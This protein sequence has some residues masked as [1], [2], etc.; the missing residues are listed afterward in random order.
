MLV[1][2]FVESKSLYYG[3]SNTSFFVLDIAGKRV[4]KKVNTRESFS[5]VSTISLNIPSLLYRGR[6]LC[7]PVESAAQQIGYVGLA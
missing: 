2:I 4:F 3:P 7:L 6:G 1:E 5:K